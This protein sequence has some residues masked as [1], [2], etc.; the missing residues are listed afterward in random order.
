MSDLCY[1]PSASDSHPLADSLFYLYLR[2]RRRA[3]EEEEEKRDWEKDKTAEDRRKGVV[4]RT[5]VTNNWT[6]G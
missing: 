4:D 3:K 1:S 5:G 6:G 2:R